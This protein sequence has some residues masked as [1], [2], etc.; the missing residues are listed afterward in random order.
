MDLE[1]GDKVNALFSDT[2]EREGVIFLIEGHLAIIE[3]ETGER[4]L[5]ALSMCTKID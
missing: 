2:I 5:T 4:W 1:V 3:F